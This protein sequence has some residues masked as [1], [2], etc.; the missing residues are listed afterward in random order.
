M[1]YVCIYFVFLYVGYVWGYICP[2]FVFLYV[3]YVW[4]YIYLYCPN[5]YTCKLAKFKFGQYN[6]LKIDRYT[7]YLL[8]TYSVPLRTYTNNSAIFRARDLK[9]SPKILKKYFKTRYENKWP[10]KTQNG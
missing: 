3:G 5:L 8:P 9:F 4:G 6:H 1:G 10:K 7:Y 2:Y